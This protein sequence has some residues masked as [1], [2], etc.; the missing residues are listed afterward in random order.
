MLRK[1]DVDPVMVDLL[2]QQ[3]EEGLAEAFHRI[4][5]DDLGKGFNEKYHALAMDVL[6]KKSSNQ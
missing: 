4:E 1:M 2:I 5:T 6:G 3:H